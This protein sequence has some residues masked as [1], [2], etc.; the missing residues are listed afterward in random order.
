MITLTEKSKNEIINLLS[1]ESKK[2]G[3]RMAVRGGGCSGFQYDLKFIGDDEIT[4][5]DQEFIVD[6]VKIIIDPKSG[7]YLNNVTLNYED[8]LMGTGFKITNPNSK[9]E[10]GCGESFSA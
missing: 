1:M 2:I 8:G 5:M 10:C 3:L 6:G 7:L 4:D 9:T